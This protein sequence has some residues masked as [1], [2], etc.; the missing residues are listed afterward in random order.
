MR[1]L[2]GLALVLSISLAFVSG[3]GLKRAPANAFP[4]TDTYASRIE[5]FKITPK[6]AYDIAYDAAK[7]DGQ[8]QFVSRTPTVVVKRWYVFGIPQPSGADLHG[9]HVN[10]DTGE[11]KFVS[12][13]KIIT[14]PGR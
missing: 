11:V 14:N 5:T 12:E 13:K 1:S 10:G 4:G 7:K 9:Y 6:Q 3:C 8:L 2:I